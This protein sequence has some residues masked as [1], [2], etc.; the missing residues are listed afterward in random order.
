MTERDIQLALYYYRCC[1]GRV[2]LMMPNVYLY[3]W[4]SD[5]LYIN[6]NRY[7]TEY[8]IKVSLSDFRNDSK[9]EAK[10]KALYETHSGPKQFYYVCPNRLIPLCEVPE[11]AGLMYVHKSKY[12]W[13]YKTETVKKAP[14]LKTKKL[15]DKQ[16]EHIMYKSHKRYLRLFVDCWIEQGNLKYDL[17]R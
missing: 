9:K 4:E 14:I 3:N 1:K 11:Y 13:N 7:V 5:I 17:K 2:Y 6:D 12:I 16:I 10:H 8:E 15:T